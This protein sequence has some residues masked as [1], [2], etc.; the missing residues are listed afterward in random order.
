MGWARVNKAARDRREYIR[1][2]NEAIRQ[3]LPQVISKMDIVS[4][5]DGKPITIQVPDLEVPYLRPARGGGEGTGR[6]TG[7]PGTES[8]L[9]HIELTPEE[10]EEILFESLKLPRLVPKA[11]DFAEEHIRVQGIAKA[12]P[13]P[14]LDRKRT[15]V[16]ALKSGGVLSRE[17]L[18]YRDLRPV[19][20]EIAKAV[21]FLCR[22]V[23]GSMTED[24]AFIVRVVSFWV[25]RWLRRN[26]PKVEIVFIIHDTI[27]QLVEEAVFFGATGGGTRADSAFKLVKSLAD[28]NYPPAAWNRYL[29]YFG[30][31]DVFGDDATSCKK[32]VEQ[33]LPTFS[34]VAYGQVVPNPDGPSTPLQGMCFEPLAKQNDNVRWGILSDVKDVVP[35]LSKVFGVTNP[36]PTED[37]AEVSEYA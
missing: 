8:N 17:S 32:I 12:G 10:V 3:K 9:I 29:V 23:S 25:S 15:L 33:L 16:Q 11:K 18:R 26:Y 31:G 4:S 28:E 21:V 24:K 20:Q 14:R 22:D 2:L 7:E 19:R 36:N 30:D 13:M 6:G 1:R 35:W 34:L 27:A 5:A 37:G